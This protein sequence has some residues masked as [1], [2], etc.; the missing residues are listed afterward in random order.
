MQSQDNQCPE[1]F[2]VSPA[3]SGRILSISFDAQWIV[4]FIPTPQSTDQALTLINTGTPQ[5]II[6]LNYYPF[7]HRVSVIEG[8]SKNEV[9]IA[10][11]DYQNYYSPNAQ[12]SLSY[13]RVLVNDTQSE[14]TLSMP[15]ASNAISNFF[16]INGKPAFIDE[17]QNLYLLNPV[18]KNLKETKLNN[19]YSIALDRFGSIQYAALNRNTT[20]LTSL[21]VNSLPIATF[22]RENA[23]GQIL[24]WQFPLPTTTYWA[25]PEA[26]QISNLNPLQIFAVDTLFSFKNYTSAPQ[27]QASINNTRAFKSYTSY[28]QVAGDCRNIGDLPPLLFFVNT[29]L[30]LRDKLHYPT[31]YYR[32][33]VNSGNIQDQDISAC[34]LPYMHSIFPS[35]KGYATIANEHYLGN[36]WYGPD[37]YRL[38]MTEYSSPSSFPSSTPSASPAATPSLAPSLASSIHKTCSGLSESI[39]ITAIVLGIAGSIAIILAMLNYF[40]NNASKTTSK[41]YVPVNLD[42]ENQN[43][44]ELTNNP[45][46]E[47]K[48]SVP[49]L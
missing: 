16:S 21:S 19:S 44:I 9:W 39:T 22:I 8:K 36:S 31:E 48:T 4:K 13:I 41:P 47:E 43:K 42:V 26:L 29:S 15:N 38:S 3:P 32:S 2:K 18:L 6:P 40:S 35:K 27:A 30:M 33:A 14:I 11:T 1:S 7:M 49:P 5:D 45:I 23:E 28:L 37:M 24:S 12:S 17:S 46:N 10:S 25:C 20:V 34:S